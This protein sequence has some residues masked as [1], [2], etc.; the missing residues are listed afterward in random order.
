LTER[1]VSEWRYLVFYWHECLHHTAWRNLANYARNAVRVEKRD[2]YV[3]TSVG[4]DFDVIYLG[5]AYF[6]DRHVAP[7][8][9][10]VA[11]YC[12]AT[13]SVDDPIGTDA[14]ESTVV[15]NHIETTV[16]SGREMRDPREAG[17]ALN[18]N[19]KP[20]TVFCRKRASMITKG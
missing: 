11:R 14:P 8:T 13:N 19:R 7:I 10:E 9:T 3:D 12:R 1:S 6:L 2:G 5:E 20:V 16:G 15:L 4:G 17:V 18:V